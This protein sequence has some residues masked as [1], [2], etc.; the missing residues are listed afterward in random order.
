MKRRIIL[1]ALMLVFSGVLALAP[2]VAVA[3][4]SELELVTDYSKLEGGSGD[5]FEFE[6]KLK[7][8]GDEI[9]VFD[10]N[11]TGPQ[12]WV[13][14]LSPSYPKDK[15]IQSIRLVPG[16]AVSDT[17]V[18]Q[19]ATPFWLTTEPGTYDI[20][21]AVS[22]DNI[23][24]SIIVQAVITA[25]YGMDIT[26]AGEIYST[27]AQADKDTAFAVN[28]TNSGTDTLNNIKFSS[29]K[30]DGWTVEFTP[31]AIAA[32]DAGESQTVDVNIRPPEKAISGDYMITLATSSKE[33]PNRSMQIRVSVE[34]ASVWGWTGII[35]I[36]LVV[37]ALGFVIIRF[38]RR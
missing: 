26:P 34:T 27:T 19:A 30:P 11:V 9:R 4:Q 37:V 5:S 32:L 28:L 31:D 22:S 12:H 7:Y 20:N 21:L 17:V 13:I 10:L 16:S 18:I 33:V 36:L 15:R 6:I 8:S 38:S 24:A 14:S 25:R 29:Q 2:P 3:A 35:I 23:S 1:T